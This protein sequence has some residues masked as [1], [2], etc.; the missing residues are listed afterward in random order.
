[1]TDDELCYI[2]A[3]QAVQL[4]KARKLSP[5][6]LHKALTKRSETQ[7]SAI[8]CFTE[9]Y[10]DEAMD[11]AKTAERK[12]ALGQETAALEGVPLAVKDAQRVKGKRTTYGSLIFKDAMPDDHSD[13]IPQRHRSSLYPPSVL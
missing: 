4:F 11:R 13:D 10:D 2:P 5:V 12:Y 8:N 6:E 3:T 1:M 7:N 9:R